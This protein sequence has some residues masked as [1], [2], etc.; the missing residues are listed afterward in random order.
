MSFRSRT[1]IALPASML[2]LSIATGAVRA[3]D[4]KAI[5]A[6]EPK[7][8]SFI[9]ILNG[10]VPPGPLAPLGKTLRNRGIQLEFNI[11][12]I[13]VANPSMGLKTGQYENVTLYDAGVDLD[14]EKL[15]ELNGSTLHFHYLYVPEPHNNGTFGSYAGDSL[16]GNSGPYIP[17]KWH[18]RQFAWEQR[19]LDDR[20][21]ISF[22]IDQASNYFALPL[23]NQPF[24]CQLGGLQTG[25]G[26]N[27]PPYSNYGARAAYSFTPEWTAQV[28]FWRSNT[29]FPFTNGWEGWNG[30]VTLPNGVVLDEPNN[31]LYL[32][33]LV[34][35]TTPATDPYPKYYEAMFYHNDGDQTDLHTGKTHSGTNGAYVGGRQTIWRE[36]EDPTA[37]SV[38]LYS[39]LYASFDQENNYGLQHELNAGVTLSG[40]FSSRPFDSYSLKVIW[41]RLTPDAGAYLKEANTGTYTNGRD[42][43]AIGVDAN[44]VIAGSL[45]FQPWAN[46]VINP[47][48][49]QNPTASGDPKTGFA[50]GFNLVSLAG[51][52][53]GL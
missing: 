48:T 10:H 39:S 36:S 49:L 33:N 5:A 27:P 44:F 15:M 47:N 9:D 52:A 23:C 53:I 16:I 46:Y 25:V 42:E 51:K 7:T 13:M 12:D 34:Y 26:M 30:E 35:K 43:V 20:L 11:I 6:T 37:A 22:G 4:T 8:S 32:A 28:G 41:D 31:S 1:T 3:E 19:L 40:P 2:A 45:I 29:A 18:L 21:D 14:L 50:I 38:S 17:E 24:L